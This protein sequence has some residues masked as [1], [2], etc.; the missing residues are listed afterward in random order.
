METTTTVADFSYKLEMI[1]Q[2]AKYVKCR[3]R[4]GDARL[5]NVLSN[6]HLYYSQ[7]A[8]VVEEKI[9]ST[10]RVIDKELKGYVSIVRYKDTSYLAIKQ[11]NFWAW[12]ENFAGRNWALFFLFFFLI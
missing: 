4:R 10:R 7:F 1:A 12:T 3:R 2:L 11:V 9:G 5:A 6:V 8:A